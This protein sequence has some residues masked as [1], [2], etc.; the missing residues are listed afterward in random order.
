LIELGDLPE[1]EAVQIGR[2][3]IQVHRVC[4]DRRQA[5]ADQA[6][7]NLHGRDNPFPLEKGEKS[8]F[9]PEERNYASS[10]SV[11]SL[12]LS[13]VEIDRYHAE[14]QKDQRC[15]TN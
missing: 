3:R 8:T 15:L 9:I 10:A 2:L 7:A 6:L 13:Y 1:D 5:L 14:L 4:Q 11:G 12:T